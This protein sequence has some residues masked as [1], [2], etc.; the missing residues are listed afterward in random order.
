[1]NNFNKTQPGQCTFTIFVVF[2]FSILLMGCATKPFQP[3]LNIPLS[4]ANY[5]KQILSEDDRH[6]DDLL[7]M[8][9][10]SG[11]GTRAAALAYGVLESLNQ[12]YSDSASGV[13][14]LDKLDYI[15]AVSGG[16][17]T[18][19][20]Y[21]LFGKQLFVDF[22]GRLLEKDLH[23]AI[24]QQFLKGR[25]LQR[26]SSEK[27]GVSDLLADYYHREIF[28]RKTLADLFASS[29]PEVDINAVDISR[30]T[31]FSFSKSQL[32]IICTDPESIS[33]ARAVAAS[34]AVPVV[35]SAISLRNYA[36]QCDGTIPEWIIDARNKSE[37][38]RRQDEAQ[39][40]YSY[41]RPGKRKY[42]HLLDG[43]L[44]DNLG[45]RAFIGRTLRAGSLKEALEE[46]GFGN[47]KKIVFI[48]VDAANWPPATMDETANHPPLESIVSAAT[49]A[50]MVQ[51]NKETLRLLRE[52]L[53]SWSQET[54]GDASVVHLSF[55][56]L[57]MSQ[58]EEMLA[59]P[60]NLSLTAQQVEKVVR[61]GHILLRSN[62]QFNRWIT[63]SK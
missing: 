58:R 20:Y 49:S 6:S 44:A 43:G 50:P 51:Y 36:N 45:V 60:T 27:F 9:S 10:F 1:M 16:S 17:F 55:D 62:P 63:E 47:T 48:V 14:M 13:T 38:S 35:F 21:A 29:G 59:I 11:G 7:F 25:N 18:A 31:T 3:P 22:R 23:A 61:S 54:G 37:N 4:P 8:A 32:R 46:R 24:R 56:Q 15:S 34:S 26:I 39:R 52:Q 19:A 12:L 30:G 2:S 57:P 28:A 5:T 41:L 40:L 42:I 33:V 53:N